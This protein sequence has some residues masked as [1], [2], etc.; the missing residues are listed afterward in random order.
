LSLRLAKSR[1]VRARGEKSILPLKGS[2]KKG[3]KVGTFNSRRRERREVLALSL[4]DSHT[5]RALTEEK[6]IPI[7]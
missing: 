4:A 1:V 2:K 3:A 7:S 5:R 6:A